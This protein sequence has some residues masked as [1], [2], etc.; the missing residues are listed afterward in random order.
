VDL[1]YT[2]SSLSTSVF[3]LFFLYT[4]FAYPKCDFTRDLYK[5]TKQFLVMCSKFLFIIPNMF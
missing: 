4:L 1:F 2:R 5:V 3:L